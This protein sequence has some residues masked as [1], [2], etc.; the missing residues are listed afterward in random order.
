MLLAFL[1]AIPLV[2]LITL[3][4][5]VDVSGRLASGGKVRDALINLHQAGTIGLAMIAVMIA[6]LPSQLLAHWE[7]VAQTIDPGSS[8][9][10]NLR[11]GALVFSLFAI[12][13]LMWAWI[14]GGQFRHYL[15]PEPI[16]F[17]RQGWRPST[18]TGA[19]DRFWNFTAS[20]ELPRL[21]WLG[22]RCAIGTMV[23][24][25]PAM[26]IIVL[27]RNGRNGLAGLVGGLSLLALGV[28]LLYL[29]MLQAHFA[30]QNRLSALFDVRTIRRDFRRRLGRG[31]VP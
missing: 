20:L 10:S 6:A 29:P 27:N 23:W 3:G 5:L 21:F 2:Q 13:Y 15:R 4:Y 31:L 25:I 22:T 26:L 8:Q 18:W 14:R 12:I 1:T 9:A 7:F 28:S 11:S 19:A 30:S 24:L 17:L 16:R